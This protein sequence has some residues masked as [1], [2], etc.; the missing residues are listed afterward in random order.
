MSA[1]GAALPCPR[2]CRAQ[3]SL[4]TYGVPV[5]GAAQVAGQLAWQLPEARAAALGN[6][7]R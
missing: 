7:G 5:P 6:A 4:V 1:E 2:G 3:G